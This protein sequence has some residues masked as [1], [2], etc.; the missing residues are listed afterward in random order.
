MPDLNFGI[1]THAELAGAQALATELE[2]NIGKAKALGQDFSELQRKL[3]AVNQ[4][5]KDYASTQTDLTAAGNGVINVTEEDIKKMDEAR[6]STSRLEVSK[7]ELHHIIGELTRKFPLLG[8]VA[9]AALNPLVFIL[10]APIAA[11]EL[12]KKRVDDATDALSDVQMPD[13]TTGIEQAKQLGEKWN[14]IADAIARAN[15]NFNSPDGI[16]KRSLDSVDQELESKKKLLEVNK[17][18]ALANLGLGKS[19][20]T[21]EQ[22]EL[23]RAGVENYYTQKGFEAEQSARQQR[24]GLKQNEQYNAGVQ[25]RLAEEAADAIKLPATEEEFKAG[26]E[27][28]KQ[29]AETLGQTAKKAQDQLDF[30]DGIRDKNIVSGQLDYYKFYDTYGRGQSIEGAEKIERSRH[31]D[32]SKEQSQINAEIGRRE[33]LFKHREELRRQAAEDASTYTTIG[34]ELPGD[35]ANFNRQSQTANAVNQGNQQINV[36]HVAGQITDGGKDI[37]R[38]VAAVHSGSQDINSQLLSALEKILGDQAKMKTDIARAE[39]NTHSF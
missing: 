23:N 34:N 15:T 35:V 31:T 16:F 26:Q 9:R 18:Q 6:E 36:D 1:S 13:L 8:E 29:R 10:V 32:A 21:P 4:S 27:A 5:M 11:F 37:A 12:F 2:R 19:S 33:A 39:H 3:D 24:L 14:G 30:I 7:R 38:L 22:Y 17:E 20:M 25:G 28:L